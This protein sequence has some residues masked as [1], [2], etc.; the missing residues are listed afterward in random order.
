MLQNKYVKL[1]SHLLDDVDDG[2]FGEFDEQQEQK[3]IRK[4]NYW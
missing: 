4:I 1:P 2:M 3:V